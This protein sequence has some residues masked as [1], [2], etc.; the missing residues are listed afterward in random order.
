MLF[1]VHGHHV[2]Q[3]NSFQVCPSHITSALYKGYSIHRWWVYPIS[4]WNFCDFWWFQLTT[5]TYICSSVILALKTNLWLFLLLVVVF[6]R[7]L[8]VALWCLGVWDC[9]YSCWY[10][11]K[12]T[13]PIIQA[14][15]HNW[16][17][18]T[19]MRQKPYRLTRTLTWPWQ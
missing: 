17:L 2:L 19:P 9:K 18:S 8:V 1:Q 13:N 4:S 7:S 16:N 15:D 10:I 5:H 3:C 14:N 6:C 11:E 12:I